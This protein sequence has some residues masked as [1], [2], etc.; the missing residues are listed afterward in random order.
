MGPVQDSAFAVLE[1]AMRFRAARGAVLAGNVANADTPGYRRGELHF[2][3]ALDKAVRVLRTDPRHLP[4]ERAGGGAYRY[5][6]GE[7]GT[8]PD[9]NGVNLDREIVEVHRNAGAFQDQAEMYARLAAL[10][11]LVLESTGS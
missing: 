9:A 8:R 6:R 4:S 3:Q 10:R 1:Q 5:E 11:R 7:R 2:D